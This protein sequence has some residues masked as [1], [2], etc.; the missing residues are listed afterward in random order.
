MPETLKPVTLWLTP[1]GIKIIGILIGLFILGRMSRWIVKWVEKF[2]PEKDPLQAAEA[3][4]R[5]HTLG[6][7][8]RLRVNQRI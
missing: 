5:A 3:M 6:N 7:I 2:V 8:L 1:S 4:K